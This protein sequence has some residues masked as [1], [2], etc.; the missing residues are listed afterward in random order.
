[1]KVNA[2]RL[3]EYFLSKY[4]LHFK[5]DYK[6]TSRGQDLHLLKVLLDKYG[7][8][9]V[10]FS[11]DSFFAKTPKEK[12]SINYFGT[13]SFFEQHFQLYIKSQPILKY[14]RALYSIIDKDIRDKM[15]ELMNE[16]LDY[17]NALFLSA[18][19]ISRKQ[20]ILLDLENLNAKRLRTKIDQFDTGKREAE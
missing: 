10:L 17:I 12:V 20:A 14:K 2:N 9:V 3:R 7:E 16:Y 15:I 5:E 19:E 13:L 8:D 6:S 18:E 11:M 4:W 1:M